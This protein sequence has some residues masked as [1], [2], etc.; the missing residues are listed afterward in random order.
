MIEKIAAVEP[1][2]E[3]IKED[4]AILD[5]LSVNVKF[6]GIM[7]IDEM[8]K[9]STPSPSSILPEV[10]VFIL[11]LIVTTL[12]RHNLNNDAASATSSLI[13]RIIF[14][15]RRSL[16][17]LASKAYF[18]LSLSYE[19]INKLE[20][21]RPTL[22]SLYRTSCIRH[23]NTGQ[24]MILNLLLRNYL[25]YNLIDQAQ[26]LSSRAV[27]PENASNN[28]FCRYLYYMGRIQAIQLEYSNAYLRLDKASR[29]AP[30][31]IFIF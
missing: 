31:G 12:L 11:T 28:Q 18:Y 19:R 17:L 4:V 2:S 25:H 16:D 27:F 30:Q 13:E 22:L 21:I 24:A 7:D 14:F 23:D 29:K 5:G 3:A 6:E 26:V 9:F 20:N 8:I 10:E 1:V 15:N